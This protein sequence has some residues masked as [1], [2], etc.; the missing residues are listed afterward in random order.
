ML[1][2][3]FKGL[4]TNH[5]TKDINP[6]FL[7]DS[8][9]IKFKQGYLTT[10]FY[11]LQSIQADLPGEIV[12]ID[13]IYLDE[14]K[15]GVDENFESNYIP[16]IQGYQFL[17]TR[18]ESENE[19]YYRFY[20]Y[21]NAQ[22]NEI[23]LPSGVG[24]QR[25]STKTNKEVFAFN[26]NGVLK[27][28]LPHI[29]LWLGKINR[30]YRGFTNYNGFYI[31]ELVEKY[32]NK[33][34]N[35][36]MEI[37]NGR[38]YIPHT[39][40]I[41]YE[42]TIDTEIG[43]M[44]LHHYEVTFDNSE[45]RIWKQYYFMQDT[46][47]NS[48]VPEDGQPYFTIEFTWDKTISSGVNTIGYANKLQYFSGETHTI[49][50][51]A[52]MFDDIGDNKI[53]VL[54]AQFVTASDLFV[55]TAYRNTN[56]WSYISVI[57]VTNSGFD[58][59]KPEF[60]LITTCVLDD[61][62]EFIVQLESLDAKNPGKTEYA[63]KIDS[64]Y[65]PTNINKRITAFAFYIKF[66]NQTDFQQ[67]YL[68]RLQ[69]KLYT[70]YSRIYL[71]PSKF[72]GIYLTQTIGKLFNEY[73][74][75]L[76]NAVEDY[77]EITGVSYALKGS[78][79][80]YPAIGNGQIQ[81]DVFYSTNVIPELYN[82]NAI[83]LSNM[84]DFLAVHT[85][86]GT[87]VIITKNSQYG[88]FLFYAKDSLGYS[89]T[90]KQDVV[91]AYDGIA[92]LTSKGIYI[93]NGQNDF[94]LSEQINDIVEANYS[95][96]MLLYDEYNKLFYLFFSNQDDF[97]L[98]DTKDKK[99]TK[100]SLKTEGLLQKVYQSL[101]TIYLQFER[102]FYKLIPRSTGTGIITTHKLNL[103]NPKTYKIFDGITLD[104]EGEIIY[105]GITYEK[106]TRDIQIIPVPIKDCIPAESKDFTFVLKHNAKLY[107]INIEASEEALID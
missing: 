98:F 46:D 3:D 63:I 41:V 57:T 86:K 50:P 17:I 66:K 65:L 99:W 82:E 91:E 14:D 93:T 55:P 56:N 81:K 53:R 48:I 1:L 60:Q 89:I 84:N 19:F 94:L 31:D 9:N 73:N 7:K 106:K 15:L 70:N 6:E 59:A 103:G 32:S 26:K 80:Y 51:S 4:Y 101:D 21:Y 76:L 83:A 39:T 44:N 12:F 38:L 28:F 47:G 92:I 33:S 74:H 25:D 64:I 95:E 102:G 5:D 29:S 69:A 72:T 52:G 68:L 100:I 77:T 87:K 79:I 90:K 34:I 10:Q 23:A 107:S 105:K 24:F 97:Y 13:M 49:V 75:R 18:T 35:G 37:Q 54:M 42:G 43:I 36:L 58:I 16:N 11:A 96:G 40:S 22:W 71:Y 62:S 104:F 20:L 30:Y 2:K 85:A 8:T 88:S 67:I 61:N 27:I 78:Q 45:T